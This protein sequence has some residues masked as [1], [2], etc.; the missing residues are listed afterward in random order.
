MSLRARAVPALAALLTVAAGL[1]V[2]SVLT[3]DLAKYGGDALYALLIFWLVLVVAPRTR[4]WVAALVA[5]GF[6]VT[7][8][9][10]QLTGVPAALGGTARSRAW[11]SAPRSMRRTCRSTSSAR[12]WAGL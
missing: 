7:I 6:S 9:L 3:G 5:A 2:R 4:G 12:R 11:C 10:F 8:E 1:S